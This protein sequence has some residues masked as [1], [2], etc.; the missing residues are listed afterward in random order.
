MTSLTD[1]ALLVFA[2]VVAIVVFVATLRNL[3]SGVLAL[4]V[5]VPVQDE[6]ALKFGGNELTWTK[7]MLG[8]TVVAWVMRMALGASRPKIDAL[9][10]AFSCYVVALAVSIVNARDLSAWAEE[11][12][13]WSAALV[14][15]VMAAEAFP[16]TMQ[17][18]KL[19]VPMS[20]AVIAVTAYAAWQI[21]TDAGPAT[22][23]VDGLTRVY[24]TFGEP[25]PFA[26]YLEM[27]I[28]LLIAVVAGW[29][30]QA[31]AWRRPEGLSL[32]SAMLVLGAAVAGT[33]AL[34]AT[35]SRG[36]Y[37]GFVAG[38]AVALWLTGGR[39]RLLGMVG[40]GICVL[41]V[42]LS[43][44]GASVLDR[45]RAES[46]ST[47]PTQ[48]TVDNWAAQER[49]AHWRAAVAM[50]EAAP[51]TGI[52]AG[53]YNVRYREETTVWRFR[54]PR[55]HAHNA[56]LQAL[57]QAGLLGGL[58]YLSIVGVVGWEIAKALKRQTDGIERSLVIGVAA[59]TAAVAVHNLVEYLHVLSLGIQLSVIWAI[60]KVISTHGE[61]QTTGPASLVA[62]R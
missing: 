59:V 38:L 39:V 49:A 62:V 46:L 25:N 45:F 27:S 23:S 43:P 41:L 55:G 56:Y 9:A 20:A 28:L 35:Q 6:F 3:S 17:R 40:G 57:A 61:V 11:T 37:V 26:G 13:R 12:Y 54:I 18:Q 42:L 44:L 30:D 16:H 8:V 5:S 29:A 52:G 48:V 4:L 60:L 36:G 10:I 21:A 19:L 34:A 14:V 53:N 31:R 50:A 7:L 58:A 51:I 32:R 22:F 47:G 15:Y 33:G 24:A 1:G 2:G